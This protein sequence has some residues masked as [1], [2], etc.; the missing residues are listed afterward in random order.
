[1]TSPRIAFKLST[2]SY[3]NDRRYRRTQ[4]AYLVLL[5]LLLVATWPEAGVQEPND[6]ASLIIFLTTWLLPLAFPLVQLRLGVGLVDRTESEPPE[7]LPA[8]ADAGTALAIVAA[9]LLHCIAL[10]TLQSPL[11]IAAAAAAGFTTR[12]MLVYTLEI[13]LYGIVARLFGVLIRAAVRGAGAAVRGAEAAVRDGPPPQSAG[14][15]KT[16]SRSSSTVSK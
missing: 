12:A 7:R 11:V 10:W 4:S 16:Y 14:S 1:M 15:A 6:A 13:L 3:A 2:A 8:P 5:L 9:E